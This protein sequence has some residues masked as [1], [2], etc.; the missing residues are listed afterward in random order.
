MMN[1]YNM[2][3]PVQYGYQNSFQNSFQPG[4]QTNF[5]SSY[6]NYSSGYG[7]SYNGLIQ[8]LTSLYSYLSQQQGGQQ[9][10]FAPRFMDTPNPYNTRGHHHYHRH[11]DDIDVRPVATAPAPAAPVVNTTPPVAAT[12]PVTQPGPATVVV[13]PEPA[14]FT[15]SNLT[16]LNNANSWIATWGKEQPGQVTRQEFAS[17]M[18]NYFRTSIP[19]AGVAFDN[20]NQDNKPLMGLREMATWY[21]A[22]QHSGQ[23]MNSFQRNL[24]ASD[25]NT[26]TLVRNDFDSFEGNYQ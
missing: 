21:L 5:Q 15:R 24:E 4:F 9:G 26:M 17:A 20:L 6:S 18:G 11:D 23:D 10:N 8:A 13:Q 16:A 3:Y 12:T 22:L 25:P 1:P 2:N 14:P 7:G 19:T